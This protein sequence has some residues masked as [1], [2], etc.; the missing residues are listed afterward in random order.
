MGHC[1]P[2]LLRDYRPWVADH[3]LLISETQNLVSYGW[4][5]N[6][7]RGTWQEVGRCCTYVAAALL[8]SLGISGKIKLLMP[9]S[10]K[11]SLTEHLAVGIAYEYSN[12]ICMN[13]VDTCLLRSNWQAQFPQIPRSFRVRTVLLYC[14]NLKICCRFQ[15]ILLP[16]ISSRVHSSWVHN[17]TTRGEQRYSLGPSKQYKP[18]I[19]LLLSVQVRC[20]GF[21]RHLLSI[22]CLS[23]RDHSV[24]CNI[25]INLEQAGYRWDCQGQNFPT[26]Q[27][28]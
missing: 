15:P 2:L 19:Q 22:A 11:T 12:V 16:S 5:E 27:Q 14:G 6:D 18:L 21:R 26:Y 17:C 24:A 9:G 23:A 4:H 13:A 3:A 8:R 7:P 10:N 28:I 1:C 20:G 25:E